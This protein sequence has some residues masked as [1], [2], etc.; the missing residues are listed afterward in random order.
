[1]SE[2]WPSSPD[3]PY[4]NEHQ[5]DLFFHKM[6]FM[7]QSKTGVSPFKWLNYRNKY[8]SAVETFSMHTS[9]HNNKLCLETRS[10]NELTSAVWFVA[11]A[12]A[13]IEPNKSPSSSKLLFP[14][15]STSAFW[16]QA[17]DRQTQTLWTVWQ[18]T[19]KVHMLRRN[20]VVSVHK[21]YCNDWPW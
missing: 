14:A 10:I 21:Y 6:Y 2:H 15:P 19:S 7:I 9:E 3:V 5:T 8:T 11:A 4:H 13:F 18:S 1:M 17:P 12:P 16:P 20:V